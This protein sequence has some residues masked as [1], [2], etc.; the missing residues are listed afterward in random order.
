MKLEKKQPRNNGETATK[1]KIIIQRAVL[2]TAVRCGK[3]D[4]YGGIRENVYGETIAGN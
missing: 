3:N 4:F 2:K 1:Q